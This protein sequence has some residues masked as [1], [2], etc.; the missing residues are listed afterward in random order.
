ME[1]IGHDSEHLSISTFKKMGSLE[2]A[3][4]SNEI[5]R[6]WL[7]FAL[8]VVVVSFDFFGLILVIHFKLKFILVKKRVDFQSR[9]TKIIMEVG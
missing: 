7:D 6:M 8:F 3:T 9:L 2:Q 1:L 5:W 4:E